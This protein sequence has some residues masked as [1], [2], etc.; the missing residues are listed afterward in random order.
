MR[1]DGGEG[2]A[3]WLMGGQKVCEGIE[4][5]TRSLEK[6]IKEIAVKAIAPKEEGEKEFVGKLSDRD[7]KIYLK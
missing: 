4:S 5:I 1:M 3:P 2:K 6:S 7:T